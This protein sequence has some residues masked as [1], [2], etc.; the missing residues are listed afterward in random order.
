MQW[1]KDKI[2][3]FQEEL[4]IARI[5]YTLH[6]SLSQVCVCACVHV[7]VCMCVCDF[8]YV[9]SHSKVTEGSHTAMQSCIPFLSP[10]PQ[11]CLLPSGVYCD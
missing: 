10:S 6:G 1:V 4:D 11:C 5:I 9:N 8:V 7:H 3:E 2:A